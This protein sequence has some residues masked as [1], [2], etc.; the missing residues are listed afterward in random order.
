MRWKATVSRIL[1]A[2]CTLA[3][4]GGTAAAASP[5]N[6]VTNPSGVG[7]TTG[8]SA[9][10]T[11]AAVASTT[12]NGQ[13]WLHFTYS[14]TGAAWIKY[15]VSSAAVGE[16]YTCGFEAEGTGTIYALFYDGKNLNRSATVALKPNTPTVFKESG[17]VV[18][19]TAATPVQ[20]QAR[21]YIGPV[22]AYVN[23]VTCVVGSSVTLVSS[24]TT[25]STASSTSSSTAASSTSSSSS[26]ATSS[27]T[28]SKVSSSTSSAATSTQGS[29]LPK[30][31]SSP[32]PTLLGALLVAA[33]AGL[34]WRLRR[35]N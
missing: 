28:S 8:W 21:T 23:D 13:S 18:A 31:G 2:G 29:S 9:A 16:Q 14:G 3:L 15:I 25:S 12:L 19:N 6:L 24:A 5:A 30:T 27:T 4:L 35:G 1:V 22:N 20:I 11:G 33:G 7:G 32:L 34:A 26:K 17:V 10:G